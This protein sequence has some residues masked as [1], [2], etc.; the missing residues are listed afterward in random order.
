[1]DKSAVMSFF[2][3]WA[4]AASVVGFGL[5]IIGFAVT[6]ITVWRIKSYTR[7]VVNTISGHLLAVEIAIL[8][9][10][11]SDVREAGREMLWPR[12]IDRSQQARLIV[13]KLMGHPYL[14]QKEKESLRAMND[15]LRLV[16]QYI[17]NERMKTDA[18]KENLSDHKK[19][20]LDSMV[21]ILGEIQ[22]RLQS[23]T[24]EV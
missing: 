20:S 21:T 4:N 11:I 3:Q 19:R 2:D 15:D 17:E 18:P 9:R 8:L 23:G 12:A 5:T 22:G 7:N 13:V 24:M 14:L 16:I 6:L 10:L 1:M